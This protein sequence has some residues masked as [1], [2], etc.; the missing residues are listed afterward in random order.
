MGLLSSILTA[1]AIWTVVA[2]LVT[3]WLYARDKRAAGRN[4]RRTPENTLLI[5]SLVGGW[6]GGLIASRLLRHKTYKMSYRI[7]FVAC[8]IVNVAV[9]AGISWTINRSVNFFR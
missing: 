8:V 5:W 7:R 1:L 4:D 6:P 2:S 9:T 3:A